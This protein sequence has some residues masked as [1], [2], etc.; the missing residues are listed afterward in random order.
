[1]RTYLKIGMVCLGLLAS[2]CSDIPKKASKP[3]A[4]Y[5]V[6]AEGEDPSLSG[7]RPSKAGAAITIRGHHE[8]QD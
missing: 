2:S 3:S 7:C 5:R 1:M 6:C 8:E 4:P